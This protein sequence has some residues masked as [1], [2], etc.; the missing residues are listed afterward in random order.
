MAAGRLRLLLR[1][2]DRRPRLP[3]ELARGMRVRALALG[4]EGDPA[5]GRRA[6]GEDRVGARVA[7]GARARR[8]AD[9]RGRGRDHARRPALARR[10]QR[11]GDR[12]RADRRRRP[13]GRGDDRL[14]LRHHRPAQGLRALAREPALHRQHLHRSPGHARLAAGDL[15]VPAARARAR[16]H[17]LVR[18]AGHRRR[19]G[20]LGRRHQEPGQG[21]R[22]GRADPHPDRPAP[23]GEDP[24]ARDQ[25]R[26]RRGRRQGRDLQARA[27]DR[28]EGRQGQARGP[29]G[30]PVRQA[31]PRRRR[32]ARACRRSATRSAPTTRS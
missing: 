1:R 19:A 23:A 28:R 30:Q 14:H 3:H 29:Q 11:R 20:V 13:H 25:R 26:G 8:R 32:Q 4:L 6:G 7:A 10:R 9:R 24:H 5:R 12:P 16:A 18:R 22:R 2:R 17:G 31:P 15:P 21:H 27:G